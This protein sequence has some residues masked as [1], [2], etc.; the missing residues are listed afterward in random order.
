M[1]NTTSS[2]VSVDL[3]VELLK[4]NIESLRDLNLAADDSLIASGLMESLD[5]IGFMSVLETRLGIMFELDM[6]DIESFETP[7]R[8]AELVN[9]LGHE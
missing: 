2:A 1:V 8:I 4:T 5:L 7:R 3:I 9:Q 6:L